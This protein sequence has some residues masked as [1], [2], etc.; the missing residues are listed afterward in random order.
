MAQMPEPWNSVVTA[1]EGDF[2]SATLKRMGV[3]PSYIGENYKWARYQ[4]DERAVYEIDSKADWS[5]KESEIRLCGY[6]NAG[7]SSILANAY[8][9][10]SVY[11]NDC[12][13]QFITQAAV[14]SY[15]SELGIGGLSQD[16]K[17][18]ST[19]HYGLRLI[20]S[21]LVD[22]ALT[23]SAD[24]P[25]CAYKLGEELLCA[26]VFKRDGED[27][28][29]TIGLVNPAKYGGQIS[30]EWQQ[31]DLNNYY[32]GSGTDEA[33]VPLAGE[34]K[35]DDNSFMVVPNEGGTYTILLGGV[36]LSYSQLNELVD[37]LVDKGQIPKDAFWRAD[38]LPSA[39]TEEMKLRGMQTRL[40]HRF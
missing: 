11:G 38:I 24:A 30:D 12:V 13:D 19:D 3:M 39:P 35:V 7:L 16:F 32:D 26:C 14:W 31:V 28:P 34:M 6:A 1:T 37:G 21:D 22:E 8:P 36:G 9:F 20:V 2:P 27:T 29:C 23:Y 33:P 10:T 17:R 4:L 25:T 15:L 40:S 18:N 5:P